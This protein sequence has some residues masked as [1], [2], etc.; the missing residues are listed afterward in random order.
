MAAATG[1]SMSVIYPIQ[2]LKVKWDY[3]R[4]RGTGIFFDIY[5]QS[6]VAW[7]KSPKK[8]TWLQHTDW[9]HSSTFHHWHHKS[10]VNLHLE[11]IS[12][13]HIWSKPAISAQRI[14]GNAI[15][16]WCTPWRNASIPIALLIL[17]Q[18][19]IACKELLTSLKQAIL[20]KARVIN[21]DLRTPKNGGEER[22]Q[23]KLKLERL[24]C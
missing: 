2:H 4:Q 18:I 16:P 10:V 11:T 21:S 14:S 24:E 8:A 9:L 17:A 13:A 19:S 5:T 22:L 23:V 3:K 20:I 7:G 6:V 1:A 12:I 15:H